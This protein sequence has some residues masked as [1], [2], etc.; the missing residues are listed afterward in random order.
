VLGL[1]LV[2]LRFDGR[3][4]Y[5]WGTGPIPERVPDAAAS[6]IA[7]NDLPPNLYNHYNDGGYLIFRLAPKV[8]VFQDGRGAAPPEFYEALG[9]L[10]TAGFAPLL[11][12]YRVNTALVKVGEY[13][14]LFPAQ[15]W[16]V[17]FWDDVYAVLVRRT[18]ETAPLLE[19]LEY[20]AFLPGSRLPARQDQLVRAAEEMRRNQ[21]ERATPD[22]WLAVG[23]GVALFRT[24][25]LAGAESEILRSTQIAP[26]QP[27]AWAYLG[28]I[29][30]RLGRTE[31]AAA[32][33]ARAKELDPGGT[34]IADVVGMIG[35]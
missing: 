12:Q 34:Q 22:W 4:V 32:A 28:W 2:A 6:F 18:A 15:Q 10:H 20:R 9:R 5:H 35:R 25:D 17:V 29:R 11:E 21:R 31:E 16:G 19:R 27:K 7:A 24:G 3:L 1:T 8:G 26:G 23:T 30:S 33:V 14:T 13:G